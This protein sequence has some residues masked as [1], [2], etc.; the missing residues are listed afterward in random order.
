MKH[1]FRFFASFL[2]VLLICLSE[3]HTQPGWTLQTNPLGPQ[4]HPTPTLGKVQFVSSTE[5][6]ITVE[7]GRLLH[8]TNGGALWTV[9]NPRGSDTVEVGSNPAV[10]LSFINATTGWFI[11]V[12]GGFDNPKGAVVYKTTNSGASWSKQVLSQWNIGFGIQFVDAN[13]GWAGVLGGEFPT[14]FS[15][16]LL[17]TTDG[18]STWSTASTFDRKI[19]LFHFIDQNNGWAVVDSI[20]TSSGEFI[21]PSEILH[22]TN[23]GT[24]WTTQRRDNT[25]GSYDAIQFVDA[26]NGWVVGS[27]G[28]ILRT[29]NG[30]TSWTLVTNTGISSN[31]ACYAVYFLNANRG[32]IGNSESNIRKVLHTMDGGASWT[33]QSVPVQ[34]SIFSIHFI[35]AN[36]GWLTSDFGGIAHTTTGGVT[37]VL[38]DDSPTLPTRF[39]LHQNYPNPFNPTTIIKFSLP[40]AGFVTLKVLNL[41]GEEV[42]TLVSQESGPGVFRAQWNAPGFASGVYFYRLQAGS[43][44]ETKKLILLR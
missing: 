11:G 22:T 29:T 40:R 42:A 44:L 20:G 34:Y 21:P 9:V 13:N 17:R 4:G 36:N 43:F 15:A 3:A 7:D 10:S 32:W 18:G 33:S 24:T 14:N 12:L 37:S 25:P 31:S 30:G 16:S 19:I 8:T 38:E 28:K 26:N 5:G 1:T 23:G 39:E 41:L 6:W 2:A 27:S 35:D